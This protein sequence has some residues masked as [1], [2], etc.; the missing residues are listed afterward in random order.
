MSDD[1]LMG[2]VLVLEVAVLTLRIY[3]HGQMD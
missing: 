3:A 2:H 1:M